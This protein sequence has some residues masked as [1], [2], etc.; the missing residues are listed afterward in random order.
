MQKIETRL[1]TIKATESQ[2]VPSIIIII[3]FIVKMNQKW[4]LKN[5]F[6]GY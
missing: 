3:Q 2:D 6:N 5:I 1:K 4:V